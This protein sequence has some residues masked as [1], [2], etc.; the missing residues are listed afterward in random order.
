MR[1][2]RGKSASELIPTIEPLSVAAD[3]KATFA[4]SLRPRRSN[5]RWHKDIGDSDSGGPE[6]DDRPYY[7]AWYRRKGCEWRKSILLQEL[8]LNA[9]EEVLVTDIQ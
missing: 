5:V 7:L 9:N 1:T 6:Q 2:Q 8:N 3:E 4:S